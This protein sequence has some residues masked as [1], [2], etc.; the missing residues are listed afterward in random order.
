M[1]TVGQKGWNVDVT[2][3][4]EINGAILNVFRVIDG[5]IYHGSYYGKQFTSSKL[6]WTFASIHGYT[7]RYFRRN[8][9]NECKEVHS[10]LKRECPNRFKR[11]FK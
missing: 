8:W 5:K 7:T 9:C 3:G 2:T 10:F 6:A 11:L 4:T 1:E